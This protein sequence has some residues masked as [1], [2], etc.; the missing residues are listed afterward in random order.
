MDQDDI[1][2][3][4]QRLL[5]LGSCGIGRGRIRADTRLGESEVLHLKFVAQNFLKLG[6]IAARF[7]I[8]KP[9]PES[10][11]VAKTGHLDR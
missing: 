3:K 7:R 2:L 11:A 4:F 6:R 5:K 8:R 1:R 9:C 10:D